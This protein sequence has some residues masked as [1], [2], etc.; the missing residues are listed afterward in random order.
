[1]PGP[2]GATV[3]APETVASLLLVAVERGPT[4]TLLQSQGNACVWCPRLLLPGAC[5]DLG[6]DRGWTPRACHACHTVHTR[7]LETY[8]RWNDH[9]ILCPECRAGSACP[10][11]GALRAAHVEARRRADRPKV[12][13]LACLSTMGPEEPWRPHLWRGQRGPELSY[14]HACGCPR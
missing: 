3:S 2:L 6:G 4:L 11:P 1:M 12:W 7:I 9:L 13:C 8:V 10:L 5:V 14:I